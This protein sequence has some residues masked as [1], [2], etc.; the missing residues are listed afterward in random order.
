[1]SVHNSVA[2]GPIYLFRVGISERDVSKAAWPGV[3]RSV[4]S[5][6]RNPS[7]GSDPVESENEGR[8]GRRQLRDQWNQD[9]HYQREELEAYRGDGVSRTGK[10]TP[11]D[12]RICGGKGDSG[13]YV[14]KEEDKMGLR[15]SD[16]VNS[17]LRI[18]GTDGKPFGKRRGWLCH[19]HDIP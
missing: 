2:C 11:G 14:G 6:S 17:F 9:V 16:T 8:K 5:R 19:R 3:R 13:F 10:E 12:Q 7:A 18:A 4:L 1:M 15:A